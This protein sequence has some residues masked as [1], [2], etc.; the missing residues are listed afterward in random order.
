MSR[1]IHQTTKV[2]FRDRSRGEVDRMCDPSATDPDV[3]ALLTKSRLKKKSK[4]GRKCHVHPEFAT[5]FGGEVRL[6]DSN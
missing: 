2:V 3:V 4:E 5:S 6:D 1:S